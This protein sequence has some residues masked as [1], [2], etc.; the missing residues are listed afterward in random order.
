M[1]T[2]EA[3]RLVG[4]KEAAGQLGL[5]TWTLYA[6]ARSGRLPSVRLGKRR[7]FALQDL[8]T[9]ISTSRVPRR[10]RCP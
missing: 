1:Q 10:P 7:L 4:V 8:E 5:S 6:W 2:G 9:L 3:T